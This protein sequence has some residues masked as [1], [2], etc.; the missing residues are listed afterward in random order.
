MFKTNTKYFLENHVKWILFSIIFCH[1]TE[2]YIYNHRHDV[3]IETRHFIKTLC[4]QKFR[5][6]F[7]ST[8]IALNVKWVPRL[9]ELVLPSSIL[10][11]NEITKGN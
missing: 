7:L 1:C 9:K 6:F 10:L 8:L 5:A 2:E 4:K 3:L 11:L